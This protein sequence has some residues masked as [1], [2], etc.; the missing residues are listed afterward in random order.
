[1]TK[2]TRGIIKQF[3]PYGLMV[4]WLRRQYGYKIDEPLFFYRGFFKRLKRIVKFL[5]PYGISNR[6]RKLHESELMRAEDEER[7][8]GS[9]GVR[10]TPGIGYD[11]WYEDNVDYSSFSSDIKAIAFYLPQF[12]T[13]KENDEWW[14]KGFTEWTNTRK[15][16]PRFIG[17]YQ[18]REP[19]D[20]IGYYDLADWRVMKRQAELAKQHG[21]YG[22]FLWCN[23]GINV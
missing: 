9:I 22:F 19:H 20:D 14:G 1:M 8:R 2:K 7:V 18:P 6:L 15:S 16:R 4:I 13:F 10:W 5:L 11:S 12:H 23:G 3:A 21:I 17:H